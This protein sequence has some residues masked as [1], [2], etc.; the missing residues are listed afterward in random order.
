VAGTITAVA[1]GG[2]AERIGETVAV[3]YVISCGGC[4]A[5]RRNREQFCDSYEMLGNTTDGGY[6]EFLAVPERNA[7]RVPEAVPLEHAAVMMCST[8]TALHALN[9]G[10]LGRGESLA[11]FGAGGLG[12]SAV[13]LAKAGGAGPLFA[14]DIDADR[15]AAAV[16]AGAHGILSPDTDP[17]ATISAAGGVDVAIDM[18]GSGAVLRQALEVLRPGGRAVAVGITHDILK[19]EPYGELIG[20]ELEVIGAN[21]HTRAEVV[22]ALEMAGSGSIDLAGVVTGTVPLDAGPI[23]EA[24]DRLDAFGAG[25]RTVIVPA[26]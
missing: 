22:E 9:R 2:P 7:I 16:L 18:V 21:D 15:V 25:M 12:Q 11:V 14:V 17:V 20:R 8:V 24:L 10:R 23:N 5:C 13:R 19:V 3:H 6:A 26:G 1:Q 4:P